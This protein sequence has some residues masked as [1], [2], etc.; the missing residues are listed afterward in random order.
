MDLLRL[1]CQDCKGALDYNPENSQVAC[2]P[3]CG[4]KN[5]VIESDVVT[6]ER[7]RAKR[8]LDMEKEKN[9]QKNEED[10]R[11]TK[12]I[13]LA[14]GVMFGVMLFCLLMAL[15]ESQGILK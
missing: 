12:E 3:F 9:R 11:S 14:F 1:K 8:D 13:L 7:I 4:S 2:C 15:L 6:I 10:K 5:I